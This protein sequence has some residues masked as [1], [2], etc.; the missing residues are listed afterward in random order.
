[1]GCHQAFPP[2]KLRGV[3]RVD[4]RRAVKSI[5]FVRMIAFDKARAVGPARS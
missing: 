4:E 2:K 1:M 5:F 3:P